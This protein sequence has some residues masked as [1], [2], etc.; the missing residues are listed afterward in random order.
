MFFKKFKNLIFTFLLLFISMP[1][2]IYAYSDYVVASCENIGIKLNSN[3]VLVVG[4]YEID[5]KFPAKESGIK[6]GDLIISI[7]DKKI[8][9]IEQLVNEIQ[10]SDGNIKIGYIRNNKESFTNLK[11]YKE[12]NFYKTGMYVK[13]SITGIGTLTYIDP[14]TKIFGALGHEIAEKNTGMILNIKDGVIFESKV[15][16]IDPSSNGIPGSKNATFNFNNIK[17]N[18]YENTNKGVFGIYSNN[19]NN[20][21][22]YK[23][24]TIDEI[25]LGNAKILTVIKNNEVEAFDI[26]ILKVSDNATKS[27][28]FEVTDEK[29]LDKSNGIV[30]G[31]SGSPII[32]NNKIIGAVTHVVVDN[33]KKGYGILITNMLEEGEN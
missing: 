12:N 22:L 31:M 23:V 11:L 26:N 13:D 18:I 14:N 17:G 7:D 30:Q 3:G 16:N 21:Q 20:N 29:L 1:Q 4:L 33:P 9:N 25:N 28:L 15:T 10:N 8:S 24:A 19:I 27:I 5:N 32:Q 2:I 6:I